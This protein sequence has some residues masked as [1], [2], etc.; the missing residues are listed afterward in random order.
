MH[1]GLP[2]QINVAVQE[3]ECPTDNKNCETSSET[4]P[5]PSSDPG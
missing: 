3:E 5:S 1:A 2:S 4:T